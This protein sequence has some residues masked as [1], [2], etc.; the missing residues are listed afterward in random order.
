MSYPQIYLYLYMELNALFGTAV[1][2]FRRCKGAQRVP[3]T[4]SSSSNAPTV[5]V[6]QCPAHKY[7]YVFSLR[8]QQTLFNKRN[9]NRSETG[10]L[11]P[12]LRKLDISRSAR[13][14]PSLL[15]FALAHF[16]L[17]RSR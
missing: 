12:A 17:S 16:F 4:L 11:L 1:S 9:G 7:Q 13:P 3:A 15:S 6:A 2:C 14:L 10:G 5:P 8:L